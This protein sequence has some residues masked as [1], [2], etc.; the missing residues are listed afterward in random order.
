MKTIHFVS[1]L[2]RSC[3]TLLCN[4]L[5]Q[6]PKFHSSSSSGLIDLIYPARKNLVDCLEFK[7]MNPADS[8]AM[9]LDWARGGILNAYNSLTNRPTVFD[10]GRSWLGYLDLLFQLFPEAKVIVTVRDIRGILTSIEKKRKSHPAY[11]IGEEANQLHY[12]TIEKRVQSWLSTPILGIPIERLRDATNSFKHKLCFVHAEELTTKPENV[13]KNIYSYLEEEYYSHDFNN[14]EQYTKEHDGVWWP[15]G[16]HSIKK[17]IM[18]IQ[19]NWDEILGK[20]LSDILSVKFDW[21]NHL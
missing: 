10:K 8:E 11:F 18:Q 9:F 7:S 2:P 15:I 16:D 21:V 4:L 19:T 20:E 13:M 17:N 1:G 6:N 12:T 3:S 14:I 5:A